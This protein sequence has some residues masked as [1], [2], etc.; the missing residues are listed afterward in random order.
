M[1]TAVYLLGAYPVWSETFLRQ[2]LAF[3]LKAGLSLY[4][5]TLFPGDTVRQPEWPE[6]QSLTTS[7][8]VS[9][10]GTP[11]AQFWLPPALRARLSLIAHRRLRS[12]LR[13]LTRERGAVHLHA[14][15][16]DLPA[17]LAAAVA[18]D[19][20]ISYSVGVHAHDVHQPK[21]SLPGLLGRARFVT[22][23]NVVALRA[24]LE[25]CPRLTDRAHII[26]HGVDLRTWAF[27][28][29]P[30]TP[31]DELRLFSAGRFVEK[32]GLDTLLRGAAILQRRGTPVNVSLAGSGPFEEPLRRLAE[33]LQLGAAV[34]WLGVLTPDQ[35]RQALGMVDVLV[36]PSRVSRGGDRDGIPNIV[37]EAMAVGVPV[38]GT[39]AGGLLEVLNSRTGWPFPPDD[40]EAL[41]QVLQTIALRP[42]GAEQRRQTARAMV[43]ERYDAARLAEQRAGLFHGV[44]SGAE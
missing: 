14:E 8:P 5:V 17:L 33:E 19:L 29:R 13:A 24:V 20:G 11:R 10:A 37:L 18:D 26:P 1:H 40:Y 25:A 4:P 16:A 2:D 36:V 28:T 7:G 42:Q 27:R 32:K 22:A 15:F 31:H 43:E 41:A 38:V 35:V 9:R 23:C 6:V 30:F 39:G 34:S 12:A 44:L 21:F 3:L